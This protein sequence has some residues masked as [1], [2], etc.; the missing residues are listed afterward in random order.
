MR[1]V[2]ASPLARNFPRN[3][4]ELTTVF[5]RKGQ[6]TDRIR[7]RVVH[8]EER[9]GILPSTHP[10]FLIEASP[11]SGPDIRNSDRLELRSGERALLATLEVM[12]ISID[13]GAGDQASS[14]DKSHSPFFDFKIKTRVPRRREKA[15]FIAIPS[16]I[17][18]HGCAAGALLIA[19]SGF[20]SRLESGGG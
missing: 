16:L 2:V 17:I 3:R 14:E 7:I 1:G 19:R 18:G 15:N 4:T 12:S 8:S 11:R 13:S 9:N 6:Q 5:E 20:L 10:I